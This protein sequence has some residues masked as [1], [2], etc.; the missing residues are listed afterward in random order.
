MNNRSWPIWQCE[1]ILRAVCERNLVQG[2]LGK[3]CGQG[4]VS[5]VKLKIGSESLARSLGH[6][7]SSAEF[8]VAI[9]NCRRSGNVWPGVAMS[10]KQRASDLA[11]ITVTAQTPDGCPWSCLIST[12]SKV[13]SVRPPILYGLHNTIG[14]D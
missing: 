7:S 11:P 13:I 9:A 2:F 4:L 14:P 5:W 6:P 8:L 1:N 3:N 10:G 12:A